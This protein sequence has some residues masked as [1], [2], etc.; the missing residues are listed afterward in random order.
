MQLEQRPKLLSLASNH[1]SAAAR[2]Q[3]FLQAGFDVELARSCQQ[4]TAFIKQGDYEVRVVGDCVQERERN[5]AAA[6][7]KRR[8]AD[9]LI[10]FLY[11]GSINH[12]EL[13]NALLSVGNDPADLARTICEQIGMRAAGK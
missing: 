13:A 2:K 1:E 11:H 8:N 7:F 10:V 5:R 9:G 4:A 12:A 6:T 3:A